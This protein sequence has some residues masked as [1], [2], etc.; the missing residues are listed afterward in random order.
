MSELIKIDSSRRA[1]GTPYQFAV[2]I[3]NRGLKGFYNLKAVCLFN[4]SYNINSTNNV[5]AWNEGSNKSITI[6]Q[7]SYNF[8]NL[9]STIQT[10]MNAVS[11]FVWTV[12]ASTITS[13]ITFATST[14]FT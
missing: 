12:T 4:S 10:M 3:P 2:D 7:G 9:S 11:G 6:P 1:T 5:L 8:T 13:L 14:N